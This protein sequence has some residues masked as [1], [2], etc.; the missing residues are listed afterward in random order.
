MFHVCARFISDVTRAMFIIG[1]IAHLVLQFW[2]HRIVGCQ[3]PGARC[4]VPGAWCQVPG[5]R[6]A[7]YDPPGHSLGQVPGVPGARCQ[8]PGAR[9]QVPGAEGP[10][11]KGPGS[12]FV[13][14]YFKNR[15]FSKL[16]LTMKIEFL[17]P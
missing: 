16:N 6:C 11:S 17:T 4:Q 5:A 3:V 2:A 9:C 10:G 13:R 14:F 8:V 1:M 12:R 15:H 7:R